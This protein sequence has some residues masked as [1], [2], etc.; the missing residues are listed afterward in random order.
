MPWSDIPYS[1]IT[2]PCR[3]LSPCDI[4]I[5]RCDFYIAP[6]YIVKICNV[7]AW[8][9]KTL[10]INIPASISL[11]RN[12]NYIILCHQIMRTVWKYIVLFNN[13]FIIYF[14]SFL[15]T[16]SDLKLG[17]HFSEIHPCKNNLKERSFERRSGCSNAA[18]SFAPP[19]RR[20]YSKTEH[21][22]RSE[23][24]SFIT[25]RLF[26]LRSWHLNVPAVNWIWKRLRLRPAF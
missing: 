15:S 25:R 22:H 20:S 6:H 8:I 12:K 26:E 10:R 2:M 21:C 1:D 14:S 16:N 17:K 9:Y 19:E 23:R 24:R 13:N 3:I 4:G 18:K 11:F 5:S 7:S